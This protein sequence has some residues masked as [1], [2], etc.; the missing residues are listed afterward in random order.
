[1][2]QSKKLPTIQVVGIAITI[3]VGIL[4]I[5]T[6]LES[7]KTK[8]LAEEN[9]ILENEIKKRQLASMQGKI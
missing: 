7:R 9:A 8:K 6:Y 3:V 2:D 5:M 1:M 4:G